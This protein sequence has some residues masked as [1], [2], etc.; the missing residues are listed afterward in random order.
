MSQD[1]EQTLRAFLKAFE[2]V[3]ALEA[4]QRRERAECEQGGGHV[5]DPGLDDLDRDRG[6]QPDDRRGERPRG[7][8]AAAAL[9]HGTG[10]A[11]KIAD[12]G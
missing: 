1:N 10:Q 3:P 11:C 2:D 7:P 9:H 6:D 5:D 8:S 4:H 12:P